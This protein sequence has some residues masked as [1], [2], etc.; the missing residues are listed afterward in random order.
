MPDSI[1]KTAPTAAPI[2]LR[3]QLTS[4]SY[5]AMHAIDILSDMIQHNDFT[6]KGWLSLSL[7][8]PWFGNW[9][10]MEVFSR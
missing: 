9:L 8:N 10:M 4:W 6:V 1:D 7:M 5:A 2:I 3:R